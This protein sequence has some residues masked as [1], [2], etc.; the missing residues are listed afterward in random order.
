[1]VEWLEKNQGALEAQGRTLGGRVL[2]Y[3]KT[4][5]TTARDAAGPCTTSPAT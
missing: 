3:L 1:M 4:F 5:A 2:P